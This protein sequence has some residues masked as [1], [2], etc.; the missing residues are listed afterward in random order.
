MSGYSYTHQTNEVAANGVEAK[1]VIVELVE[2]LLQNDD[3]A[4][5]VVQNVHA[6]DGF[7]AGAFFWRLQAVTEAVQAVIDV[8]VFW[9]LY[10]LQKSVMEVL[11]FFVISFCL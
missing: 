4:V 5:L 6:P 2:T 1:V 8:L 3:V 9:F 11:N 10:L 7:P